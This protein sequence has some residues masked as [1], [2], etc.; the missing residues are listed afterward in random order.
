MQHFSQHIEQPYCYKGRL[1]IN[2]TD[3]IIDIAVIIGWL[4]MIALTISFVPQAWKIIKT[5][6]TQDISRGMYLVT[7]IGFALWTLYGVHLAAWPLIVTNC[8]CLILSGFIYMMKI[9]PKQ[10]IEMVGDAL[11]P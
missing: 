1:N 10:R 3:L 9:L 6:K 4:A 8:I 7:V 5:R 11:D 2:R